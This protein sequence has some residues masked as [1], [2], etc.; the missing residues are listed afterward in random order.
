MPEFFM[1]SG[2]FTE[3]PT[4]GSFLRANDDESF[5]RI[6][7]EACDAYERQWNESFNNSFLNNDTLKNNAKVS[8]FKQNLL[9]KLQ[10]DCQAF[11]EDCGNA[12]EMFNQVSQMF[13][14]KIEDMI[15]ESANVGQLMPIKTI[16]FPVMVKSQIKE[17]YKD[18][19]NEEVSPSLIVKKRIEHRIAYDKNNPEKTWEFPQCFYDESF[20][21]MMEAGRGTKL[22][23]EAV[24]LPLFNW[25]IVEEL[26]DVTVA[27]DARVV[28]DVEIDRVE[29][30]DGNVIVLNHPITVNLADNAWVG[31]VINQEYTVTTGEEGHKTTEKKTLQD[32]LSGFIDWNT[33]LVSLTSANGTSGVSKVYFKG[34]L[35]NE[36]NGNAIRTKYIQE[37]REWKI[38]EGSKVDASYSL[39]ELQEH[40]AL[41]NMDLYQK[42]YND[43]ALLISQEADSDG[44]EWLDGEYQKY[45]D[46]KLN[47]LQWNPTVLGTTFDCDQ[48]QYTV[49]LQ[50]EYISNMLKFT[51]DRFLIA[52]ADTVKLDGLN[53]VVYGNPRYISFLNPFVKWVF[54]SGS[55]VGGVKLDY[56]Y[57]I[58]TSGDVS[59]YVVS[60]KKLDAKR[61][62]SLRFVG[63]T[64]DK[65][66]LTVKRFKF[67]TDVVT[68]KESAYKDDRRPGGSMTY[69]WGTTRYKDV[70]L[71]AIFGDLKFL[72][73]D[74]FINIY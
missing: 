29:D 74:K 69:V 55:R 65:Q 4:V 70:S 7:E 32:N 1:E 59:I 51:I 31:G 47:P 63:F 14:N 50:S 42:S 12:G 46:L 56:S 6:Y 13:D 35:S 8:S 57:G 23:Y 22:K 28:L 66:T 33:H 3:T 62:N 58:M 34:R 72:N 71:Q 60:S 18:V 53:F 68:S 17:S 30:K 24:A 48:S 40:K 21:E 49:A 11:D 44:Y 45:K 37:D 20:K 41:L 67:S 5:E 36:G 25:N 54:R 52:L 2:D 64:D 38:G 61:Y 39:E 43:L 19:V 27:S 16:D 10:E 26:T 15:T 9:G 73:I